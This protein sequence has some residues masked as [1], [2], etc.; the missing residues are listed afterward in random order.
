MFD[1]PGFI[2]NVDE[3]GLQLNNRTGYVVAQKG[4]KDVHAISSGEKGETISVFACCNA[5]GTFMPPVSIFK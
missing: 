1:K 4:S 2:F 5:E 3:T